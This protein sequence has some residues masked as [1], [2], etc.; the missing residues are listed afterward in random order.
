VDWVGHGWCQL[1]T[2]TSSVFSVSPGTGAG[3]DLLQGSTA[4]LSVLCWPAAARLRRQAPRIHAR[5]STIGS[6]S[7]GRLHTDPTLSV[8]E[9][10][11]KESPREASRFDR[12]TPGSPIILRVPR[13]AEPDREIPRRRKL[14]G[15][16]SS[17]SP[18]RIAIIKNRMVATLRATWR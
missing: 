7:S 3:L 15:Y 16:A 6:A 10:S 2:A 5:L 4:V 17:V 12:P 1:R 11:P 9:G 8:P 13:P 18:F 14:D